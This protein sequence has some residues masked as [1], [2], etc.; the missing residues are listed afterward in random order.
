MCSPEATTVSR[1]DARRD[2]PLGRGVVGTG[3]VRNPLA[4]LAPAKTHKA[5]TI[6]F[7]RIA[8]LPTAVRVGEWS[9]VEIM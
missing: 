5:G 9:S 7:M 1:C 6:G 8:A 2:D 4:T 3:G